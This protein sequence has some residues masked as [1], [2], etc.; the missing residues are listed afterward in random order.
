MGEARRR[1][2]PMEMEQPRRPGVASP[3]TKLKEFFRWPSVKKK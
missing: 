1:G 3:V 2:K